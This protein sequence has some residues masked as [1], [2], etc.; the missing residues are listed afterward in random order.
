MFS[1]KSL[2]GFSSIITNN[3]PVYSNTVSMDTLN[4]TRVFGSF[5]ADSAYTHILLGNFFA[6]ANNGLR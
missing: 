3:P 1:K 5:V 2:S 4:W 6:D